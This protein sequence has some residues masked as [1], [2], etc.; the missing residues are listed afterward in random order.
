MNSFTDSVGFSDHTHVKDTGIKA[1][2]GA[3]YA[4][5]NVIERHFTLLGPEETKDGP[6]SIAPSQLQEIVNFSNLDNESRKLY[7]KASVP[8]FESMLG[9]ETRQLSDEELLNRDYYRGRFASANKEKNSTS[10]MVFNWEE[11]PLG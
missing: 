10:A 11:V 7:I 6:V 5:A 4:G 3:I 2:I 1:S 8:E 9:S